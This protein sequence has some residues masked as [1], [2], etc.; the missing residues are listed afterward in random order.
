[1]KRLLALDGGGIRGVLS[2]EILE[3]L[4]TLLREK[5]GNSALVLADY[6]DYFAGTSTGG[7]IATCLS[8]GMTVEEIKDLYVNRSAE[9]FRLARWYRRY[10]WNKFEAEAITR[11]FQVLFSEDGEGR[12]PALLSSRK[13]RTKL[14]LVM[15]NHTTG[16]PWPVSNNPAAKYND[17]AR[18][19]C[20]LNIPIWKLVR[21]STAAP[22]FFPPETINFG[23]RRHVFV[24]GGITP[25]NNPA[26]LLFLMATLPS[27]NLN[28]ET[29][30]DKLLLISI[31]TGR[32]RTGLGDLNR[33]L[34]LIDHLKGIPAALMDSISL[35]QDMM[36][37][38][39]GEC[40]AG[41]PI[42]AEVGDLIM[43]QIEPPESRKFRY[44]RYDHLFSNEE[45]AHAKSVTKGEF[46]L[47]NL[48]LI[49]ALQDIGRNCAAE[50]VRLEHLV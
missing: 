21:A 2:L 24:D 38:I 45:I 40:V 36:C 49:P 37:R 7:I 18:I 44:V 42:D 5:T 33:S 1:M 26:L 35:Q 27:Y 39:F 15:R 3:R 30:P 16:S 48:R 47:D 22:T 23:G 34:N 6:I 32:L 19:D 25:Y 43:R 13:L 17:P 11:M 8:W 10:L 29:G 41:D 28:W 46:S 9:M 31:G 20:N 50:K 12:E 4:E 14:V